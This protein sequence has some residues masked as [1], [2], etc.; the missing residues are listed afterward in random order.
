MRRTLNREP[1]SVNV[2][3]LEE[4]YFNFAEFKGI[5]SNK[6]YITIDQQTFEEAENVY[7]DQDEQLR[8]RPSVKRVEA[9]DL[10]GG[11]IINVFKINNLVFYHVSF[12][13]RYELIFLYEGHQYYRPVASQ[14]NMLWHENRY[15]VFEN[16]GIEAF[17]IDH[18]ETDPEKKIVWLLPKDIVFVPITEIHQGSSIVEN[19][20]ENLFTGSYRVQYI[21]DG[22]SG[23]PT[24]DLINK[25]VTITLPYKDENGDWVTMETTFVPNMDKMFVKPSETLDIDEVQVVKV[26]T[27]YYYLAYNDTGNV[28]YL[29]TTGKN[30]I[31]VQYPSD[32]CRA[33]TLSEDGS[34]VYLVDTSATTLYT[35]PLN[36]NLVGLGWTEIPYTLPTNI[37]CN[38]NVEMSTAPRF[39]NAKYSNIILQSDF[40]EVPFPF[41][42]SPETGKA[43]YLV[44]CKYKCTTV[45]NTSKTW[46]QSGTP[47]TYE[48]ELG[49][50]LLIYANGVVKSY[51]VVDIGAFS[52][53]WEAGI[54]GK[55]NVQI[56]NNLS[57]IVVGGKNFSNSSY[58]GL[59]MAILNNNV[60]PYY[61]VDQGKR[62]TSTIYYFVDVVT[63]TTVEITGTFDIVSRLAGSTLTV[64]CAQWSGFKWF[65]AVISNAALYEDYNASDYVLQY[66]FTGDGHNSGRLTY[67]IEFDRTVTEKDFPSN[68]QANN[69]IKLSIDNDNV[70]V[71]N[72]Y[73]YNKQ[74]LDYLTPDTGVVKPMYFDNNI[75]VY[76]KMDT[77]GEVVIYSS[78]YDEKV[79]VEYYENVDYDSDGNPIV[80]FN[81]YLPN[82]VINFIDDVISINEKIYYSGNAEPKE[83]LY[84]PV[85]NNKI[86][87]DTVTNLVVFSQTSLGIFLEDNVYE[88]Q[89]DDS[90]STNAI[91]LYLLTPTKLK[92]GCK[93][94]ADILLNYDGSTIVLANLKG[95][96]A[97][98]YQDFVQSTE[99]TYSYLSENVMTDYCEFATGPI[100]LYQFKDYIFVYQQDKNQMFVLDAR[101]SSWW[102]WTNIG[103]VEF[104]VNNDSQ[105]QIVVDGNLYYYDFGADEIH[106]LDTHIIKWHIK[107]QKLH[108]DAP[109][110]YKHIRS[111]SVITSQVGNKL[112][113]KLWFK[114]YRNLNNLQDTD[115][116]SYEIEELSTLIKRVNFVKTNAFQFE[117]GSD[118]MDKHPVYFVTPDIAIKYR[119]TERVR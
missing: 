46:S 30:F 85:D 27:V 35:M 31:Q 101:K 95:V 70:L 14:V 114:N 20:S 99:Q 82:H 43:M 79:Y 10:K 87:E 1:L 26:G 6:N 40:S 47:T 76:T 22:V 113:F 90:N 88:L 59:C 15:I 11:K 77:V 81:Y 52:N 67:P 98:T 51:L 66:T 33:P 97:L 91:H 69:G 112:R 93:E 23:T 12:G 39:A 115:V 38:S 55:M 105:L 44:P 111:L 119:I 34:A 32:T 96:T 62:S 48:N 61:Y 4:R 29:S 64:K 9:V 8:T 116:V 71:Q 102:K 54:K 68:V 45:T 73:Y 83:L 56:S 106:D 109:N 13:F 25:K 92:L 18:T 50:V 86:F 89:Y 108:F 94:G 118:D 17:Y 5:C 104:L 74:L 72:G 3:S 58:S 65:D 49:W 84:F 78:T 21:F 60:E 24:T 107:S 28:C 36:G 2:G 117:I 42:C 75:I 41:G 53:A 63:S 7:V 80:K 103:N 19:T 16:T 37:R 100:K 110:N 57:Y